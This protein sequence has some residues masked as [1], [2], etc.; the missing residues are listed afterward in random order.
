MFSQFP[1]VISLV[2]LICVASTAVSESWFGSAI[3]STDYQ[4][5]LFP[6]LMLAAAA[7]LLFVGF[8]SPLKEYVILMVFAEVGLTLFL[9]AFPLVDTT[10]V[11]H[12]FEFF[13]FYLSIF[14]FLLVLNGMM[15]RVTNRERY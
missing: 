7:L 12:S 9:F 14:G 11:D 15:M 13:K 10:F 3:P 8:R 6:S 2:G 4:G 1:K 5:I